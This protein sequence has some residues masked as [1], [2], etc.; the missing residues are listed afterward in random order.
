MHCTAISTRHCLTQLLPSPRRCPLL[1]PCSKAPKVDVK[2]PS[3]K[4]D[5]KVEV[6]KVDIKGCVAVRGVERQQ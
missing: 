5:L 2:L 3:G 1:G 4:V 6:P